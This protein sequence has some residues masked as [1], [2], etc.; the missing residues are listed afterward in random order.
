MPVVFKWAKIAF[1]EEHEDMMS[2]TFGI[3]HSVALAPAPEFKDSLPEVIDLMLETG[4]TRE[5]SSKMIED[6]YYCYCY[7]YCYFF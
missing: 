5:L 4:K 6:Y 2:L 7:Y 1:E 3:L